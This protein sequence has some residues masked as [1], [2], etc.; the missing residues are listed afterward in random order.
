MLRSTF[1]V[2]DSRGF[3]RG[4]LAF[5]FFAEAN[6]FFDRCGEN[7]LARNY[8]TAATGHAVGFQ[9]KAVF[10]VWAKVRAGKTHRATDYIRRRAGV[11]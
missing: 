8:T 2:A 7:G 5:F 3:F 9:P 4:P 11:L 1:R 6:A 10:V